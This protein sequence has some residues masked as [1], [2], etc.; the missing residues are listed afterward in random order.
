MPPKKKVDKPQEYV[1]TTPC[2][3]LGRRWHKGQYGLFTEDQLP[4]AAKGNKVRHFELINPEA[5][6]PPEPEGPVEVDGKKRP[7]K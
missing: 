1:C 6:P 2:W 4:K 3:H 7:E 5:P